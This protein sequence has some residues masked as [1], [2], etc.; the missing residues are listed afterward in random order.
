MESEKASVQMSSIL[1]RIIDSVE[2]SLDA[3]SKFL[4]VVYELKGRFDNT[5]R[6]HHDILKNIDTI[7]NHTEAIHDKMKMASNTTVIDM[8]KENDKQ[9]DEFKEAILHF[10]QQ[11]KGINESCDNL[12]ETKQSLKEISASVSSIVKADAKMKFIIGAI[13]LIF[14]SVGGFITYMNKV[15][16]NSFQTEIK[17]VIQELKNAEYNNKGI[18][19]QK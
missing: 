8:L 1:D 12:D 4:E 10:K 17:A 2:R 13:I 11:L 16:I 19:I 7:L 14:T 15:S 5:E 9:N 18:R 3:Q 6:D